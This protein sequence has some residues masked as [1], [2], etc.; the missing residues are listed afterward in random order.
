LILC[1]EN[2]KR[3]MKKG[4]PVLLFKRRCDGTPVNVMVRLDDI[5]GQIVQ[6]LA[7]RLDYENRYGMNGQVGYST[8]SKQA[9]LQPHS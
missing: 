2:R 3:K 9:K 1:E 5:V 6:G 8:A 4:L 7:T